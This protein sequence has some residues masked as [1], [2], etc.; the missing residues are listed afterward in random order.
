MSQRH[1]AGCSWRPHLKE[2]PPS[3][4]PS[5]GRA[6]GAG[7]A[8]PALTRSVNGHT[9][10]TRCLLRGQ[11]RPGERRPPQPSSTRGLLRRLWVQVV[12]GEAGACPRERKR[13]CF[14]K[15]RGCCK[16][17]A[18]S[19]DRG[20]TFGRGFILNRAPETRPLP[21]PPNSRDLSA[22][23][24]PPPAPVR[25]VPASCTSGSVAAPVWGRSLC[26]C[27]R[28]P[29]PRSPPA[30]PPLPSGLSPERLHVLPYSAQWFVPSNKL[31]GSSVCASCSTPPP[32]HRLA[33]MP[34]PHHRTHVLTHTLSSQTQRTHVATPS[35]RPRPSPRCLLHVTHTPPRHRADW[36]LLAGPLLAALLYPLPLVTVFTLYTRSDRLS[37]V[38]CG[39]V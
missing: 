5:R 18:P 28:P 33:A 34:R 27:P 9:V 29:A 36:P 7:L 12:P 19:S 8:E 14:S 38:T 17:W 26:T 20:T 22:R 21:T 4:L 25:T 6:G 37:F 35:Q 1:W 39:R 13:G 11:A 3:L 31:A 15:A 16:S 24:R 2:D 10:P 23:P 32:P 30:H